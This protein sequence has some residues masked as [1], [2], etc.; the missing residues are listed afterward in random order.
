MADSHHPVFADSA[1]APPRNDVV[2]PLACW[3]VAS[4]LTRRRPIA[5]G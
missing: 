5:A 4:T 3:L 1:K 2:P